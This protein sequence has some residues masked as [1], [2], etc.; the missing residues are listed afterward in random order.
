MS[1]TLNLRNTMSFVAAYLKNQPQ[2]INNMEPA[3][4]VGNMVL[5]TILG[6]PFRWRQNRA[7][8]SFG[9]SGANTDY[10]QAVPGFGILE[11]AWLVDDEGNQ[12]PLEGALALG[13]NG[14]S[15]RPKE[16]APQF[17][18]NAGNIT[19]R[20]SSLPDQAYTFYMDFQKAAPLLTSPASNWGPVPDYFNH[21]YNY[22]YLAAI[23][24]LVNDAAFPIYEKWFVGRLLSAQSGLSEQ[25]RNIFLANWTASIMT[26]KKSDAMAA[27][28]LSGS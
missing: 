8:I 20:F 25:E 6:P 15:E 3:V 9:I 17:D 19:F 7:E 2:E 4:M 12:Y 14:S 22:G 13:V 16:F 26:L 11:L 23:S 5:A 27:A 21:I 10:V 18:D 1:V 24:R 28:G